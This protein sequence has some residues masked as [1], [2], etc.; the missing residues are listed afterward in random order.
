MRRDP[1]AFVSRAPSWLAQFVAR[2]LE[3]DVFRL[4]TASGPSRLQLLDG[5]GFATCLAASLATCRRARTTRA[6]A[7]ALLRTLYR[8]GAEIF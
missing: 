7:D 6:L 2:F 3:D 5:A 1:D 4:E 8:G